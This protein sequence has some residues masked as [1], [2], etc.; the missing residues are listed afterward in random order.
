MSSVKL[1]GEEQTI[2][3]SVDGVYTIKLVMPFEDAKVEVILEDK[4]EM[5]NVKVNPSEN[6]EIST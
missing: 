4:V 2:P 6:G 5:M 1:N 3:N